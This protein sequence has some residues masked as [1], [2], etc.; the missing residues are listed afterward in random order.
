MELK[1]D[2]KAYKFDALIQKTCLTNKLIQPK[3][4]KKFSRCLK[5]FFFCFSDKVVFAETRL[6]CASPL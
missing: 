1:L 5:K 2:S 6:P 4:V 3:H